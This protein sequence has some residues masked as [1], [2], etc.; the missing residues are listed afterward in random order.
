MSERQDEVELHR[1]YQD[2]RSARN[3]YFEK[4]ALLDGGTVALVIT[5]VLGPLHGTIRHEYLLGVGLTVL[6]FAMLTLLWRNLQ[7]AKLEFHAAANAARDPG[8]RH[9]G[10]PLKATELNKTI[11]YTE[12]IGA[13]L[14]AFG[15]VL[16]LIEVWL[17]L[18]TPKPAGLPGTPLQFPFL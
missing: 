5:A 6:V 16:L 13:W 14:S 8:Y 3:A 15:I 10:G 1:M 2:A 17:L 9:F 11:F 7:A 12:A 18:V 4:L